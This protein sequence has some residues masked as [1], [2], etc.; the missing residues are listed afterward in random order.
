MPMF[1]CF[2]FLGVSLIIPMV[3]TILSYPECSKLPKNSPVFTLA[4]LL[5]CLAHCSQNNHSKSHM[6]GEQG[7][8]ELGRPV[9]HYMPFWHFL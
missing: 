2:C 6:Y 8:G 3:A 9:F 4:L 1:C 5:C 7:T